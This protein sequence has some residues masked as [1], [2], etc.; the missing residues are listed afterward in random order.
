MI[1]IFAVEMTF[2]SHYLNFFQA[3]VIAAVLCDIEPWGYLSLLRLP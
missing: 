1:I 3:E 2:R